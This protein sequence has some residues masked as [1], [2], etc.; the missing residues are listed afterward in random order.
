MKIKFILIIFLA[1]YQ[2]GIS[3]V[4]SSSPQFP[5]DTDTITITYDATKGNKALVGYT[6]NVY[7]H[8]GVITNSS[9]SPSDWRHVKGDP[10]SWGN[11]SKEPKM[12]RIGTNLYQIIIANP[13]KYYGV[14]NTETIL[15]LAFVFRSASKVGSD[16]IVGRNADGSDIFLK[17][18]QTGLNV[19]ITSPSQT[20]Y[21]V[22]L[23]D[24]VKIEVVSSDA[25]NLSLYITD[26]LVAH[27]DTNHIIYYA[28]AVAY[29]DT[30]IK[31]IAKDVYNH[32]KID[33]T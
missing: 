9:T 25:K 17:I 26:N 15:D 10:N 14:P 30:W 23:N 19:N 31:A 32:S 27:T 3:Q 13:R 16:Y 11:N 20:P 24:S 8:T 7:A 6:G 4:L 21:F 29:G 33:S 18:Y 1:F 22:N 28:K 12:T 2:I 5:A